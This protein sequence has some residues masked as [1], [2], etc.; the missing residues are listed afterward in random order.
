MKNQ[1]QFSGQIIIEVLI[2]VA[3]FA[4]VGFSV[5]T[6]SRDIVDVLVEGLKRQQAVYLAKEGLEAIYAIASQDF[7]LLPEGDNW[8]L[9][10]L[11]NKWVLVNEKEKIGEFERYIR[12]QDISSFL[13][14][15][16]IQVNL[17]WESPLFSR[18][19]KV[20]LS[21]YFVNP[22]D[23]TLKLTSPSFITA[24]ISP[25]SASSYTIIFW[26]K[27]TTLAQEDGAVLFANAQ[28]SQIP[29]FLGI[30]FNETGHYQLR[31]KEK[32]FIIGEAKDKWV[33]IGISWDGANLAT[34]LDGN[35]TSLETLSLEEGNI[36]FQNYLLGAP[37]DQKKG[38]EGYYKNFMVFGRALNKE[39]ILNLFLGELPSQEELRVYWKINEGDGRIIKDYSKFNV[40]GTITGTPL[41]EKFLNLLE[42]EEVADF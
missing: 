10:I 8:G 2:G 33:Q 11:N 23:F 28:T 39:E 5:A 36:E 38:F 40:Q 12:I 34:Y 18:P 24:Q 29:S 22:L 4:L 42:Y 26:V 19:R 41:W 14:M 1:K 15:K 27:P 16:K 21:Q 7:S 20:S 25:W 30:E 9:K 35:Q 3:L 31:L 13:E 17:E 6:I 37:L 32:T